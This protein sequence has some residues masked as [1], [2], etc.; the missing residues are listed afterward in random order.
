MKPSHQLF[1]NKFKWQLNFKI[2][3]F[4]FFSFPM[5]V[6]LGFWQLER[7]DEKNAIL[8]KYDNNRSKQI[9]N[10]VE[11]DDKT[12]LQYRPAF[13]QG[14]LISNQRIFLD[15]KVKYGKPGYEVYEH[16]VFKDLNNRS[17]KALLVNRGWVQASLNRE[18]LPNVKSIDSPQKYKGTL[19]K[20]LK[21]GISL[22][23]GITS[24]KSWPVRL[25]SIDT[26]RAQKVF[27]STSFFKYQLRLDQ[28][29]VGALDASWDTVSVEPSKHLGYAVQWFAMSV[30][31]LI[32][33]FIANS[34]VI[35]WVRS[36]L[37]K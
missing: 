31:L 3:A 23:D 18:I 17:N 35:A 26:T 1:P 21:G 10:I 32:M 19:Y 27:Q 28:G 29:S 25:G 11:L 6:A 16:L 20:K 13:I 22:D 37:V 2:I 34:N 12:D 8:T 33:T 30:V 9:V 15:Y 36:C 5:L 24:P 4:S 7:A 14:K